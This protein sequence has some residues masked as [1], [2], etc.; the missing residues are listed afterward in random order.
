MLH[1][2]VSLEFRAVGVIVRAVISETRLPAL[3]DARFGCP[4]V[5]M[6]ARMDN[7]NTDPPTALR[8]DTQI[9]AAVR[10]AHLMSVEPKEE[11]IDIR[12]LLAASRQLE[13]NLEMRQAMVLAACAAQK[14]QYPV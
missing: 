7:Q 6:E 12:T 11:G 14:N 10:I 3:L 2:L 9:K 8:I 4:R 1:V 5:M 13:A